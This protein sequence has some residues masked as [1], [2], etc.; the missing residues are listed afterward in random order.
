[1]KL[2]NMKKT[3]ILGLCLFLFSLLP[4]QAQNAV[5]GIAPNGDGSIESPFEISTAEHF[6]WLLENC[7]DESTTNFFKDKNIVVVANITVDGDKLPNMDI[8][9]SN[10]VYNTYFAGKIDGRNFTITI[11]N[12][13]RTLGSIFSNVIGTENTTASIKD[14]KFVLNGDV[15]YFSFANEIR[16]ANVNN[17]TVTVNGDVLPSVTGGDAYVSGFSRFVKKSTI[18]G[19][20]F[21]AN[22]VGKEIANVNNSV[23]SG[24]FYSVSGSDLSNVTVNINGK[25]LN[26]SKVSS[27]SGGV[28]HFAEGDTER[29]TSFSNFIVNIGNKSSNDGGVFVSS[30]GSVVMSGFVTRNIYGKYYDKPTKKIIYDNITV[31]VYGDIAMV[32]GSDRSSVAGFITSFI[33]DQTAGI[34]EKTSLTN[35]DVN[36]TGDIKAYSSFYTG[37]ISHPMV[38]VCGFA[39]M[40][41]APRNLS[42][43]I[44]NINI[45]VGGDISNHVDNKMGTGTASANGFSGELEA[46]SNISIKVGGD[47]KSKAPLNA[48]VRGIADRITNCN[49]IICEMNSL[50]AEGTYNVQ[51]C[52]AA[53][54]FKSV[55]NIGIIV[56]KN[57]MATATQGKQA[58]YYLRGTGFGINGDSSN[59][60]LSVTVYGNITASAISA[61]NT[62]IYVS[63][64]VNTLQSNAKIEKCTVFIG[65]DISVNNELGKWDNYASIMV[66]D[67]LANTTI[68]QAAC[69]IGGCIN[70]VGGDKNYIGKLIAKITGSKWGASTS[71]VKECSLILCPTKPLGVDYNTTYNDFIGSINPECTATLTDNTFVRAD[72]QTR[73]VYSINKDS[74][75]NTWN[76]E[77]D[78]MANFILNKDYVDIKNNLNVTPFNTTFIDTTNNTAI[79][80]MYGYGSI[81]A[82]T[83]DNYLNINIPNNKAQIGFTGTATNSSVYTFDI[84]QVMPKVIITATPVNMVA[85]EGGESLENGAFPRPYF[86]FQKDGVNLSPN[87]LNNIVFYVD[88]NIYKLGDYDEF[89]YE[90]PLSVDF[91]DDLGV[92][93]DNL[94]EDPYG[95]YTMK[96]RTFGHIITASI[97]SNLVYDLEYP[98]GKYTLE[99]RPVSPPEEDQTEFTPVTPTEPEETVTV[100]T[101]VIP[102]GATFTNSAG[103]PVENPSSVCL[104][105]DE[106]LDVD[107]KD[108]LINKLEA[109]LAPNME[110][111]LIYLDLVD[112]KNGNIIVNSSEPTTVYYPYPTGKDS[113]YKF[114]IVHFTNSNRSDGSEN[115]NSE[116]IVPENTEL[117]IKFVTTSFSPFAIASFA[118]YHITSIANGDGTIS[119]LGVTAVNDGDSQSYTITPGSNSA[120][121]SVYVDGVLAPAAITDGTYTFSNVTDNH[122][123]VVNFACVVDTPY[124]ENFNNSTIPSFPD[125]MLTE[126][127]GNGNNWTVGNITS[128]GFKSKVAMY[129]SHPT[130]SANAWLYTAGVKLEA[131][132]EYTM[133]FNY[134]N[135]STKRTEKLKVCYGRFTDNS[136]MTTELYKN[137]SI[138]KM[139]IQYQE[140]KFTPTETAVYF[141]GFNCYS[142]ANQMNLY[143]DNIRVFEGAKI[144]ASVEGNG[145]M[146]ADSKFLE[147]YNEDKSVDMTFEENEDATF[148]IIPEEGYA[149]SDVIVD[150]VSMGSLEQYTFEYLNNEHSIVAIFRSIVGVNDVEDINV[151]IYSYGHN[152]NIKVQG[153][154]NADVQ[155]LDIAGRIIKSESLDGDLQIN[156]SEKGVYIVKITSKEGL[157]KTQKV[158]IR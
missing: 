84:L 72:G 29:N 136:G 8:S 44:K 106:I 51:A 94:G 123:I 119:P 60:N 59:E 41:L 96:A 16:Y 66:C 103:V 92:K 91:Y 145:K 57:I 4:M 157:T 131:G 42:G 36:V 80:S 148:Q 93:V 132:K 14:I 158:I 13:T 117:G 33:D 114:Q 21:N 154:I 27:F 112:V 127:P 58:L 74:N 43:E 88:G 49:D 109:I 150:G 61:N 120:I 149:I 124:E 107:K 31:N 63:G 56:N 137:E 83:A 85:Y 101:P 77:A 37:V 18:N 7:K 32:N 86:K 97:G 105:Q 138:N 24:V 6:Y 30:D 111:E 54:N 147:I 70:T 118:Q 79:T 98:D 102:S 95:M 78:K 108:D 156:I 133:S 110:Y 99:V 69:F 122:T 100:S 115:D 10:G 146:I 135:N 15:N 55:N 116:I 5:N 82:T 12:G 126:N 90:Y 67:V 142:D 23:S 140:T 47:I 134:G 17:V 19:L 73:Q 130:E 3:I 62:D 125:C 50:T 141:F 25:V 144:K 128:Y 48:V 75:S 151:N 81:N 155:I 76:I 139:Y 71:T 40:I 153:E 152:I 20:T 35:I 129:K 34:N 52:G 38:D 68:S 121:S 2:V 9:T 89:K 28:I 22:N 45:N 46:A 39:T 113:T 143:V 26:R 65:G 64:L 11:N 87:E 104:V 53:A 1:M